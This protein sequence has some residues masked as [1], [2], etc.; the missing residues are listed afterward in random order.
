M[1]QKIDFNEKAP[2]M[3]KAYFEN[4]ALDYSE[5]FETIIKLFE[6]CGAKK[7]SLLL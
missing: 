7:I 4:A 5:S 6:L 3:K 2:R 1:F